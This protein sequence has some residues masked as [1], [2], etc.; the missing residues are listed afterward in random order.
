MPCPLPQSVQPSTA[1]ERLS[2]VMGTPAVKWQHL[3]GHMTSLEKLTRRGHL[4]MHPVQF[5][6]HNQW[7][8]SSDPPLLPVCIMPELLRSYSGGLFQRTSPQECPFTSPC[9]TLRLFTDAS[10]MGWGAHL[11]SHQTGDMAQK[12]LHIKVPELLAVCVALLHFLPLVQ[13]Q[14]VML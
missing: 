2:V 9:W 1:A 4:H 12:R 11:L 8:Q 14:P 10:N 13:G 7:S 5:T 6:H 3:L